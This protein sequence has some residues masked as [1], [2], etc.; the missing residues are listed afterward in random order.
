V[1]DHYAPD[2]YGKYPG[3]KAVDRPVLLPT[4]KEYPYVVRGGSWDDDP[5]GLRSAV[6][7]ASN[8]EWSVQDPQRPQRIWWHTDAPFA[9]LRVVRPYEEQ[10]NLKGFK[11]PVV[12]KKKTAK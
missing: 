10:D 2:T 6:R 8:K 7:R 12:S 5:E 1:L 11:S 9:G 4:D 3:D